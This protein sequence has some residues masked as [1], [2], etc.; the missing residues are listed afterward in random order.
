ME[1]KW[2][3]VT[4]VQGEKSEVGHNILSTLKQWAKLVDIDN[5]SIRIFRINQN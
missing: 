2:W 5:F 4:K 1:G 3:G